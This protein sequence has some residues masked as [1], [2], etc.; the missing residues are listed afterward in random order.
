M[1]PQQMTKLL[2]VD[3]DAWLREVPKFQYYFNQ[4][5]ERLPGS[6]SANISALE[7]RLRA[8]QGAPTGNKTLLDWVE[9][10]R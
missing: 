6:I 8:A 1:T 7:G 5:G 9:V 3:V 2:R 4:F 10:V